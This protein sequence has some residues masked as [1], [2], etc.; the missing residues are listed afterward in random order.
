MTIEEFWQIVG[1]VH[2]AS[3]GDMK[4]KC[5][6]LGRELR[7]LPPEA[8]RSFGRYFSERFYRADRW[9]LWGAACLICRG[10]GDDSF[11]DFRSTL[12]SMGRAIFENALADPDSLAALDL[13]RSTAAYEGYQYV[14]GNIGDEM[15]E[16]H[17]LS[18]EFWKGDPPTIPRPKK[19]H[20]WP[21]EEWE[22][23]E[24]YPRLAAK[25]GHKDPP[26]PPPN[27]WN[28]RFDYTVGAGSA[29]RRMKGSLTSLL[30]EGG[31]IPPSGW[32]PPL[33]IVRHALLQGRPPENSDRTCSWHPVWVY[34][35][36][37]WKAVGELGGLSRSQLMLYGI[38]QAERLRQDLRT[39][40]MDRYPAWLESLK[41]PGPASA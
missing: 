10:C 1:R 21:F 31:I 35:G 33:R 37:Y 23:S 27:T 15:S 5:E 39:T 25:Y 8:V 20:G 13:N 11:M 26:R 32:I 41:D 6:I 4:L 29:A 30:L 2:E 17:G 7:G 16:Q 24:H 38:T 9:D 36:D 28:I 18:E 14:V 3:G 12:I 22:M 40:T 34:E 19:P